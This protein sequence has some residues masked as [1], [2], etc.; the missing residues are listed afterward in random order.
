MSDENGI[1]VEDFAK[2]IMQSEDR[3]REDSEKEE[4]RRQALAEQEKHH[5]EIKRKIAEEKARERA[6]ID[7]VT[8]TLRQYGLEIDI[9]GCGCCNSPW[10]KLTHKGEVVVDAENFNIYMT[11]GE[12]DD[13]PA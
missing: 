2:E 1:S 8:S 13:S 12:R 9:G 7:R 5:A 10:V 6:E 4:R 3:V 11:E